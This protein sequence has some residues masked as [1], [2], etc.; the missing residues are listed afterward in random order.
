MTELSAEEQRRAAYLRD[1]EEKAVKLFAE[2]ERNLIQPGI[3][4]KELSDQIHKLGEER[5]GVRTHWHKRVVRSG[6]NALCAFSENPPNRTIQPD[7]LLVVDLGPVFEEWEAD[8]GRTY[9]LGDDPNKIALRDALEPL[10]LTVKEYFDKTPD[11]TGAQLYDYAVK[12]VEAK[13]WKFGA[14]MAG[15]LVG[16]F[17]HERIPRDKTA[18]YITSGNNEKMRSVG[19]D[20][21][22][23]HWILEIHLRSLDEKLGGF[24]EQILTVD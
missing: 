9:V 18:L 22:Q 12:S 11:I 23:R 8:F 15:H 24:F 13:G 17:P 21:H 5:H 2:I 7:D 14:H 16:L 6:E 20:G 10:W 3:T 1:A 19:K 4:D